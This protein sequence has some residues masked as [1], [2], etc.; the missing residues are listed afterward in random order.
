MQWQV[1]AL[2]KR[3]GARIIVR[4]L[5]VSRRDALGHAMEKWRSA[6]ARRLRNAKRLQ[7]VVV[8][9][10]ERRRLFLLSKVWSKLMRCAGEREAL[11]ARKVWFPR[12]SRCDLFEAVQQND[13]DVDVALC[14]R[15]H[16]CT[17]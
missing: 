13:R 7:G 11:R 1:A 12:K 9:T 17:L 10:L 8:R 15:S 3:Q 16:L 14:D 6:A 5:R 2:Q 4:M